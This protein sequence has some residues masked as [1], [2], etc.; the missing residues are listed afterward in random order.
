[1]DESNNVFS[2]YL[3]LVVGNSGSGKDSIIKGSV[4]RIHKSL[5]KIYTPQRYITRKASETEDNISVTPQEF[6]KM[7]QEN[8]FALEWDIYDL[9][10]GIPREIDD[11]LADGNC[12]IINVSRTIIDKAKQKYAN[13]KVVFIEVPFEITLKR[14]MERAREKGQN[15]EERIE[16]AR[17][18]QKF[19]TADHVIDNSG[20]LESSINQFILYLKDLN[21][22]GK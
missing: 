4:Q 21:I 10:Y 7:S 5:K 22:I 12:V 15:L 8:R 16:R 11:W 14:I 19:S 1:M 17:L 2:G 13:C 6:K 9:S 20:S 3:I 18:N